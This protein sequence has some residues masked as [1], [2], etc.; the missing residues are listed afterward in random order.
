[1]SVTRRR[2]SAACWDDM[3]N[4]LSGGTTMFLGIGER[5]DERID[6]V[7]SIHDEDQGGCSTREKVLRMDWRID[8]VFPRHVPADVDLEGRV[9][10]I[11]PQHRPQGRDS[12]LTL[13]AVRISEQQCCMEIDPVS[14]AHRVPTWRDMF[15]TPLLQQ[16]NI[17]CFGVGPSS[18]P[19]GRSPVA[20]HQKFSQTIT[21]RAKRKLS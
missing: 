13:L 20:L 14:K 6:G 4:L 19:P 1:M 7:G 3:E 5:L 17:F 18:R 16:R 2:A 11:W 15:T 12:E 21:I 8:L 10:C 9:R